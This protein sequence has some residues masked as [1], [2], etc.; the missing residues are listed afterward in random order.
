[1]IEY[2]ITISLDN[3]IELEWLHWMKTHHI[4]K[5][6]DCGIFKKAKIKKIIMQEE[7]TYAISYICETIDK[8]NEY[9]R[10]YASSL[11]YEYI[12]KYGER[13]VIFRTLLEVVDEIKVDL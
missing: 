10:K 1:M 3:D 2:N 5:V 6:I 9:Q 12:Q 13:T 7:I 8:I 11:Q 4:P